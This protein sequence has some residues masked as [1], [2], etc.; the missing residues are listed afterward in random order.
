M[1]TYACVC[2]WYAMNMYTYM[3]TYMYTYMQTFRYQDAEDVLCQA[4]SAVPQHPRALLAL[5]GVIDAR[6]GARRQADVATLK[7][8]AAAAAAAAVPVQAGGGG[9][10]RV[11]LAADE[12]RASGAAGG[13]VSR[14][15]PSKRP[16]NIVHPIVGGGRAGG[17]VRGAVKA[18]LGA[19]GS[20]ASNATPTRQSARSSVR[21]GATAG[22][23]DAPSVASPPMSAATASTSRARAVNLAKPIAGGGRELGRSAAGLGPGGG[24]TG[25]SK[26][27]RESSAPGQ[28]ADDKH[29]SP[30]VRTS[31]SS[32]VTR[33]L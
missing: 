6:Y 18:S 14:P 24:G 21:A 2:A 16:A 1:Y 29:G 17:G 27:L 23:T 31:S 32:R 28:R 33:N 20:Q 25:T 10:A 30:S 7:E 8:A 13:E 9:P 22:R 3:C 11:V 4:L 26:R 15:N 5:S 12:Q 19:S